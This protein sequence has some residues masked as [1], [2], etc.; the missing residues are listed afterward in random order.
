MGWWWQWILIFV[1]FLHLYLCWTIF[2]ISKKE[3]KK[4]VVWWRVVGWLWRWIPRGICVLSFL[5]QRP[6]T[7]YHIATCFLFVFCIG[8]IWI[9]NYFP[10][11]AKYQFQVTSIIIFGSIL[12]ILQNIFM[13]SIPPSTQ[14]FLMTISLIIM[15]TTIIVLLTAFCILL[16]CANS[17]SFSCHRFL[18]FCHPARS[19]YLWS[20]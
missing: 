15:R 4:G 9:W 6:P 10:A 2:C 14:W 3:G 19:N 7:S 8:I 17:N 1:A 13:Q 16:H 18:Y 5:T 11:T 12:K 20:V